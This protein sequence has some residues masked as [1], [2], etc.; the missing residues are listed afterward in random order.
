MFTTKMGYKMQINS[1]LR[2]VQYKL[3]KKYSGM[4][5][6]VYVLGTEEKTFC[7]ELINAKAL[8]WQKQDL[9][10]QNRELIYFMGSDG[11][12][13][14][15]RR[16][17]IHHQGH[18]DSFAESDYAWARDIFGSLVGQFKAH[19]LKNVVFRYRLTS[20]R[21]ELGSLVGLEMGQYQFKANHRKHKNELPELFL[22]KDLT[23]F[24]SKLTT[25]AL[26]IAESV[27]LSRHLVNLPPNEINP[28]TMKSVIR[29]MK[30]PKT[31]KLEIW[32]HNRLWGMDL[33]IRLV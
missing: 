33:K 20:E 24:N 13:W 17:S 12:V 31:V 28:S 4:T 18:Q 19:H 27:N 14:I 8:D 9:L 5:G 21:L 10:S 30:W 2:S 29:K 22:T 32:D 1:W 25:E 3:P 23:K 6:F 26:M 7:H 16:N 15:L 11:P